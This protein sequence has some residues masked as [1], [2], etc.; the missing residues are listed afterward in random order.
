MYHP[1]AALHNSLS[2]RLLKQILP[3][4]RFDRQAERMPTDTVQLEQQLPADALHPQPS[5]SSPPQERKNQSNLAFSSIPSPYEVDPIFVQPLARR[6][7]AQAPLLGACA[8]SAL[9]RS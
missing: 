7:Q 9:D 8:L 4:C 6:C 1:A 2:A 3:A 5:E